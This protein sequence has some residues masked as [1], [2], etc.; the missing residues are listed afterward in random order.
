M[1]VNNETGVINDVF[2]IQRM[3]ASA[4]SLFH[5][6]GSQ[7]LGKV[8]FSLSDVGA[9]YVSF[10]GHKIGSLK[11]IGMLV[12]QD[13]PSP[14]IVGGKQENGFR[15]GT[16]NLPGVR[17]LELAVENVDFAR[18]KVTSR[19]RD[20][21]EAELTR[22]DPAMR[23]NGLGCPRAA[24][25]S[26]IYFGGRESQELL[27]FLSRKGISASNGSACTSGAIEPSHVITSLG[28]DKEY[29]RSCVR[30]SLGPDSTIE[31]I[32]IV[33]SAIQEFLTGS[34]HQTVPAKNHERVGG[35]E[36]T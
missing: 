12:A 13:T 8:Q 16:A 22:I 10:S 15:A 1:Y 32:K 19:L 5:I 24:N 2:E 21:L 33:V 27:F 14:L 20:E 23:I 9:A 36:V 30:F 4:Q 18:L 6:D 3:V 17:S 7:A 25:T 34:N 29:A 31:Q 26:N 35:L 11:G 28:F